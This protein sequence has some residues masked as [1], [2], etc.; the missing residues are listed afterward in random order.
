M[1]TTINSISFKNK[2]VEIATA[3]KTYSINI[4]Q[5]LEHQY[6]VNQEVESQELIKA[7]KE[8]PKYIIED[9]VMS[10]LRVRDYC[11]YHMRKKL[12]TKFPNSQKE[13]E[14]VIDKYLQKGLLDDAK[15]LRETI[16]H[17]LDRFVGIKRIYAKL[18]E[19]GFDH[20][21]IQNALTIEDYEIEKCKAFELA[22]KVSNQA[23][24]KVDRKVYNRLSYAGYN[25]ELI[26]QI[27][28]NLDL[29]K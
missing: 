2:E 1:K 13:I 28:S 26:E 10:L 11:S 27:I 19:M 18:E 12:L 14:Q 22:K 20:S 17:D 8:S 4:E 6:V 21:S 3:K 15:Y 29:V 5:Y 7:E 24:A 25:D 23:T 16:S 9:Y